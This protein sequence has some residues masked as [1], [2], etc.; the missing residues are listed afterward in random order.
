MKKSE[1]LY[2]ELLDILHTNRCTTPDEL[3]ESILNPTLEAVNK[4]NDVFEDES[5]RG[6]CYSENVYKA[7]CKEIGLS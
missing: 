5:I 4:I 2:E 6:T 7:I 1:P 3:A